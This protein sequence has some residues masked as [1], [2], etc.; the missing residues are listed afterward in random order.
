MGIEVLHSEFDRGRYDLVMVLGG[1]A[2]QIQLKCSMAD[3]K[4]GQVP[5]SKALG[6]Q[7][8]G[9]ILWVCVDDHLNWQQFWWFGGSPEQPLPDLSDFPVLKRTTFDSNG[10]RPERDGCNIPK[11]VLKL[12]A[13]IDVVLDH[14]F[15]DDSKTTE[16]APLVPV[17][18]L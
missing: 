14:L 1:K 5:I 6:R 18:D 16:Q 17:V 2:R 8:S 10:N 7:R 13:N 11:R 9:C 3:G 15:G 4:T 12:L